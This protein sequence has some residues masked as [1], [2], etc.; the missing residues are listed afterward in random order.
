VLSVA[1]ERAVGQGGGIV[2]RPQPAESFAPEGEVLGRTSPLPVIDCA[3]G[4]VGAQ[5]GQQLERVGIRTLGNERRRQLGRAPRREVSVVG[6]G[7]DFFQVPVA[8]EQRRC[9]LRAE[10]W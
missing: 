9:G 1:A 10:P 5:R 7:R 8:G 2:R 6:F 3:D 4:G